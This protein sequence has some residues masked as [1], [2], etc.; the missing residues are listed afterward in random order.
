MLALAACNTQTI[1][2]IGDGTREECMF[3]VSDA[4]PLVLTADTIRYCAGFFHIDV[5]EIGEIFG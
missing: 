4:H 1:L 5:L 2:G 3:T